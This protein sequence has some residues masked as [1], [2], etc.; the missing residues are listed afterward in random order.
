VLQ[1]GIGTAGL[2]QTALSGATAPAIPTTPLS[3]GTTQTT[4]DQTALAR[5][6]RMVA[7]LVGAGAGLGMRRQVFMVSM[8]C[9]DTHAWA[10][11]TTWAAAACCPAT[12]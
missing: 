4:L 1:R 6:L 9:F 7:Q 5:Q 12:A 10:R 8:G 3:N 2:L 11:P